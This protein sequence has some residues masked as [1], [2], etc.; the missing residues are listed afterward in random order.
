M[1]DLYNELNEDEF[2]HTITAFTM[3]SCKRNSHILRIY[4][5]KVTEFHC[6]SLSGLRAV[7]NSSIGG[8]G[9][10]GGICQLR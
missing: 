1:S 5:P 6:N 2:G 7:E 9:G 10:G 8:G 4:H 3:H